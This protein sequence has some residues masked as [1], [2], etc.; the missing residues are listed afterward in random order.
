MQPVTLTVREG[1]SL[2]TLMPEKS[3][4]QVV[5]VAEEA[6]APLQIRGGAQISYQAARAFTDE[7]LTRT[8][9]RVR[10]CYGDKIRKSW[11]FGKWEYIPNPANASG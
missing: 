8:G 4:Q 5:D 1:D 11:M 2:T 10:M 7:D 3:W 6:G 9:I